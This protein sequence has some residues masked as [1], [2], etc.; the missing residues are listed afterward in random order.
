MVRYT[1]KIEGL[2]ADRLLGFFV[3]WRQPRTPAEHVEI[4]R[5]SD[6]VVLA[7]EEE[8]DQVVGFVT[9]IS[10]GVQAA[11]IPLLEVLPDH[12]G[13]GIGSEL[14]RR[15]LQSLD[16]IPCI[17]LTCDPDVQPFYERLGMARS[18]GMIQRRDVKE[19]E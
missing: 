6:H 1:D 16:G 3:G 10:D 13:R 11:F 19:A 4:L 9:G 12:Q 18:V 15:M 5:G 17:D 7:I 14:M 8:T 2:T